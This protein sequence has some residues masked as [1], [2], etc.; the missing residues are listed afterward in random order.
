MVCVLVLIPIGILLV[1]SLPVARGRDTPEDFMLQIK[2]LCYFT[3]GTE[4]VRHV[5]RFIYNREEILQFNSDVGEFLM[6]RELGQS[7][8]KN[9]NNQKNL[10]EQYQGYVNSVCRHNYRLIEPFTVQRR[11]KPKVSILPTRSQPL[12]YHNLLICVATDFYPG[13]I[14]VRWFRNGQEEADGVM[15]SDLIQNGDWTFQILVMLEIL[16]QH[17]DV[18]SC[19]VEHGSL[20]S[21]IIVEWRVQ[22]ESAQS[23]ILSG[24]SGFIVGLFFLVLGLTA[25]LRN[26]RDNEWDEKWKDNSE[27]EMG[28]WMAAVMA[29]KYFAFKKLNVHKFRPNIKNP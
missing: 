19:Q 20:L 29:H 11:V 5:T 1:M 24:V 6:V 2:G 4:Q 12:Q 27:L 16:P 23:K 25:H 13:E 9:W 28:L 22:S 18:Y 3:N 14:K 8:A 10:L 17:R 26:Q 21:S 15:S 7:L